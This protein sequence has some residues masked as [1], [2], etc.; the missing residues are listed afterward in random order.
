MA[1]DGGGPMQVPAE[2]LHEGGGRWMLRA[3]N[4]AVTRWWLDDFGRAVS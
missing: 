4:G 3:P 2:A 1:A